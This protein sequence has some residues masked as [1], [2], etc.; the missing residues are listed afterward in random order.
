LI[1]CVQEAPTKH[2]WLNDRNAP[3]IYDSNFVD[4]KTKQVV[5]DLLRSNVPEQVVMRVDD[6]AQ[7]G[8]FR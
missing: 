7:L 1:V 4:P 5:D 6:P 3:R 8:F 2:V